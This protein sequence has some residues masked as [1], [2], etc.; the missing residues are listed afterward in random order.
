MKRKIYFSNFLLLFG[1]LFLAHSA[2]GQTTLNG[3]ITDETGTALIGANVIVKGTSTGTVTDIDGNFTFTTTESFPIILEISYTGYSTQEVN[4][5]SAGSAIN[6]QLVEGI[7][8][9]EVVVS[10]SRR[11]EKVQEA[12]ASVSV[13]GAKQLESS[14]QSTDVVR[15]LINVPGVQIQQQSAARINIEMRGGS[16]LFSTGV[17]PIM[18]YRSLIGPGIGT[19]QSDASGLSTVDLARIEVVRGA[20]SA[21]YGPGVASGVVHF[22]T[23]NPIDF[24]GTTIELMGGELNTVGV[25]ARHA[26]RS[27]SRKFG[28]KI[29]AQY[30]RGNEFGL[31]LVEDAAQIAKLQDTIW[32]PAITGGIV[33]AKKPGEILLNNKD[34]DPDG[35]GNPLKDNWWNMAVNATLEFRPADDLSVFVSGGINQSSAVFYNNQGEG[36][37]QAHEFWSQARVQKGGLFAQVFYVDNDG[38]T[39]DRP[40]FLYQT[41]LRTPIARKQIEGQVQYNF[42]IPSFLNANFTV[43]ADYRQAINDTENLV[44]GRNEDDDDYKIYGAYIQGKFALADKLDLVLAGRYDQFNFLKEGAFSPRAA[45]VYKINSKHTL[46]ASYNNASIPPSALQVN[47]D[48]PVAAPVPGVF[49]VWL[50]G[51]KTAQTWTDPVIDITV[52]GV[53][54][55]P[56]ATPGLPLAIPYALVA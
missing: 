20:G 1:L 9:E 32:Q 11:R 29:N 55:L 21:L 8:T 53:P 40:T 47:I 42:D 41:G 18:D 2:I 4:V 51:Q 28:Y 37:F 30:K 6:I 5:T 7:L 27:A 34:L 39:K 12:P 48:F 45:I 15:N 14:A 3:N 17:F 10:A 52:P 33:D 26:G 46:R 50:Y 49:D 22:V 35:D 44:Y 38:G 56:T 25:T 24:P 43:G 36:L 13:I 16:S 23:K 31:D 19:F 54:D